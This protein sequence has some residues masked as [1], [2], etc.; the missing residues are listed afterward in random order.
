MPDE[1][2]DTQKTAP[3]ETPPPI[4]TQVRSRGE[5]RQW[6]MLLTYLLIA[7]IVAAG[8]VLGGR[9]VYNAV[10]DNEPAQEIATSTNK[11]P[12]PPAAGSN[13]SGE[14]S[15]ESS[16]R[17]PPSPSPTPS[18]SA[19]SDEL[20]D[21]GPKETIAIFVTATIAGAGLHYIVSLRR[22]S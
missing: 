16:S 9:W 13:Q 18:S 15:E 6:L 12:E 7:L 2:K 4:I 14:S 3:P 1:G 11:A 19:R 10:R 20:A 5:G 22:A 21:T 17:P 8:V